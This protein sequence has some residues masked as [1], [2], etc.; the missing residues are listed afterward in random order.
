MIIDNKKIIKEPTKKTEE[1]KMYMNDGLSE[2]E[3]IDK[4]LAV[5][6]VCSLL[7]PQYKV[8]FTPRSVLLSGEGGS[9]MIDET[10]FEFL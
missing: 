9:H 3:A 2:K 1:V 4:K 6:S 5:Q 10:N 7:F 8:M